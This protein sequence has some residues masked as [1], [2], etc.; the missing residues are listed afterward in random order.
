VLSG[1]EVGPMGNASNAS[2]SFFE[3]IENISENAPDIVFTPGGQWL[4]PIPVRLRI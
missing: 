4:G 2:E 1:V 3:L